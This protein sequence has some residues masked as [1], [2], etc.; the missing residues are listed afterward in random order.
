MK[1]LLNKLGFKI[2]KEKFFS[3]C[4][5]LFFIAIIIAGIY[6]SFFMNGVNRSLWL[7]EAALAVSFTKRSLWEL[8]GSS[9]EWLQSAPAG[10]LYIVKILAIVFGHTEYVLRI[11]SVLAYVGIL[12]LLYVLG[13]KMFGMKYPLAVSAFAA[14]MTFLLQY[15]NVFKPYIADGL[16]VLL[17]L[18]FFYAYDIGRIDFVSLSVV[19]AALIWFSNPV[20]FFAGGLIVSQGIFVLVEKNW[21]KLKE[22]IIVGVSIVV[23]FGI[24]YF[25]W[26]REV[27]EGDGMQNYW[28]GRQFPL[29]PKSADDLRLAA[30][31]VVEIYDH[32]GEWKHLILFLAPVAFIVAIVKKNKYVIGIYIGLLVCLFASYISMFP[33]QDRMWCFYYPLMT[34]IAFYGLD[35]FVSK[36]KEITVTGVL[37]G[38]LCVAMVSSNDG[39][40]KYTKEANVYWS[41]EETNAQVEYIKNNI[42]SDEKVYVYYHSIP[43]FQFKNGYDT[44]SIGGYEDNVIYGETYFSASDDYEAE[45]QKI[46]DAKK[47]YIMLSHTSESRIAGLI[48]GTM[49]KGYL[50][51]VKNDYN[52]PLYYYCADGLDS[53]IAVNLESVSC[54]VDKGTVTE[55]IRIN[56]TGAAFINHRYEDV[57]IVDVANNL[58]FDVP[59]LIAPGTSV[60]ITVTYPEGLET[61]FTLDTPSRSLARLER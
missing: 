50:E 35:A 45:L 6:T 46:Y 2:E 58:A 11:F 54:N 22:L 12:V 57:L 38:V 34:L 56:N 1:K 25:Y 48:E 43:G 55:I 23:S 41:G 9:F 39:I 51:L 29:I 37:I 21:K 13:K 15:S 19:W 7:D 20:C 4:I 26:L 8:T 5:N 10:W 53:K 61:N 30:K 14:S 40:R 60:D 18:L 32:F 31:L 47:C 3:Y 28:D 52:T 16:F 17:V 42:Q 27:A 44:S 36:K 59:E 24:N 49:G 33:V